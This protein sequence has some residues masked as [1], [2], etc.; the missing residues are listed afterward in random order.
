[1]SSSEF[2]WQNKDGLNIHAQDWK[3]DGSIRGAVA[4][5]HGLG[6]H[7]GRYQHVAQALN[8]AGYAMTGFDLP[9]HGRS[10]GTRGHA[11]YD[12]IVTDI[13]RLLAEVQKR[14]P[15]VPVFL[16]G[17]S[18]GGALVLYYTLKCQPKL[19]GAI[20]TSPGLATGT[21][22]PASKLLMAKVMARLA[23]A[24]TLDNGLDVSNLS[25]DPE[26]AKMYKA[27]PLVHPRISAR[28]GLDLL[29]RGAWIQAHAAELSIPLLLEQGSDDYLVSPPATAAFAQ[30]APTDKVTFKVWQGLFHETHNEVEKKQV[31]QFMIDWLNQ[32]TA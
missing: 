17:H 31:L 4:L 24:F 1:M 15:G 12:G 6:E 13:D 8:Q 32:Q 9:G 14:Y 19:A 30:A 23:P 3:P 20:V 29:T 2:S 5:V 28:L 7:A 18:L 11:S 25:H 26:I 22:L 27:D 21:P 16:Y 10:G